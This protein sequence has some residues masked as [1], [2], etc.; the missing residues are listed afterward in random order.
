MDEQKRRVIP[1]KNRLHK[2]Y[3][4]LI[5]GV[6]VGLTIA[7][8]SV[9]AAEKFHKLTGAQ[10]KSTFAGMEMSDGVHWR[11]RYEPGGILASQS[12]GKQRAGKWWI[13]KDDLCIDLGKD[14][15]GCYQVWI[16]GKNVEFRRKGLD[17]SILEGTLR[18]PARR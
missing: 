16:A 12:M 2:S 18:R 3:G 4:R 11:D 1:T 8:A 17:G 5:A 15:G 9:G 13:E 7:G 14:Q 6:I 10:I